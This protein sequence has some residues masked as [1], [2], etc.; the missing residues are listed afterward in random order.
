MR[1]L[2]RVSLIFLVLTAFGQVLQT[3]QPFSSASAFVEPDCRKNI[4]KN[5]EEEFLLNSKVK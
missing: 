1:S 5:Y 3:S 4:V 2:I